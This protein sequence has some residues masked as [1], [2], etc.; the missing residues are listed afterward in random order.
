MKKHSKL[1]S[2]AAAGMLTVLAVAAPTAASTFWG[3]NTA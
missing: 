2:A 3:S 1:M